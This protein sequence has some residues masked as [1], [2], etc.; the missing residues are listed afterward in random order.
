MQSLV[1]GAEYTV[2]S[3]S[4]GVLFAGNGTAVVNLF[5]NNG[6]PF[7]A[8]IGTLIGT[9]TLTVT[10]GQE[11][12]VVTTPLV[13]I[14]P[15]GTHQVVMELYLPAGGPSAGANTAPQSGLSYWSSIDKEQI[16]RKSF[17]VRNS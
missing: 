10:P 7:P 2:S 17:T 16:L 15:A 5:A 11:G 14:V 13:A 3:V 9:S 8:E 12:T 4:F 1:G 6:A